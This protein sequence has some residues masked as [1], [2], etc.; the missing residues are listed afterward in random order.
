M[1]KSQIDLE[2]RPATLADAE[3][4]ADL[5]T[6]RN[7]DDPRDPVMQ[8]FWWTADPA[9]EVR[10]RFIAEL[11]GAAIAYVM[12]RHAT[13]K[14]SVGRF[15][16]IRVVVHPERWDRRLHEQLIANVESWLHAEGGEVSVATV[17]AKLGHELRV[18]EDLGYK[19]VRLGREWE[20]DLVSNRERLLA[21]AESSRKRMAEQGVR[22]LT[23]DHEK[24]PRRLHQLY[25]VWNAAEHDVPTTVPTP[26]IPYDEWHHWWFENPGIRA[27][28]LWIASDSDTIVGLSAIEYPPVRGLPWTAFTGTSPAARGRGIARALK[29]E[30][31]AQAIALGAERIRT[32]ND[33]ENAPILHLNS[34]MGYVPID[35]V[36]ELHR[37]LRA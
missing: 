33:G 35:P 37:E 16:W 3:L 21:G 30:T 28:R 31:V 34:E 24:D 25:E 22:M 1:A 10:I 7:P 2:L 18:F 29:Y 23:L 17:G 20:L 11:D 32:H 14:D 36:L 15:G 19:E 27:D 12:A 6:A 13:W 26:V 5:E 4:V 8:R 9:D